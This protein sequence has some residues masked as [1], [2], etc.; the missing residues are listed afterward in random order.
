MQCPRTDRLCTCTRRCV[1]WPGSRR[2]RRTGCCGTGSG[3][4]WKKHGSL[5]LR[6]EKR[7][8]KQ[9][10]LRKPGPYLRSVCTNSDFCVTKEVFFN[11][12]LHT[13]RWRL[14]L[15]WAPLL[16]R[17]QPFCRRE[18]F[19]GLKKF[20]LKTGLW[21]PAQPDKRV[22][23]VTFQTLADGAAS[24]ALALGVG[25][26]RGLNKLIRIY[27]F[28]REPILRPLHLQLQHFRCT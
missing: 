16:A 3:C 12:R 19:R 21:P 20:I 24:G 5:L 22:S 8:S 23:F 13:R 11:S 17:R 27:R 6:F 18:L 2:W 14:Q 28:T 9:V 15:S 7:P 4:S 25:A 10:H 26:A 1:R